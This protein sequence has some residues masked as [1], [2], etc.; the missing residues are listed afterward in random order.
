[1]NGLRPQKNGINELIVTANIGFEEACKLLQQKGGCIRHPNMTC[2]HAEDI[3]AGW[4]HT[5]T[6]Y[7]CVNKSFNAY[8]CDQ[9]FT[10]G[11]SPEDDSEADLP[12][13]WHDYIGLKEYLSKEWYHG[14]YVDN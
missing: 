14:Y 10:C 3:G 2:D 9:D 13:Y 5:I 1:M 11:Y 8:F 6:V 4:A 7:F 12:E